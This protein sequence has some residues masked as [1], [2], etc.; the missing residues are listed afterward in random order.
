[1]SN[2]SKMIDV[3]RFKYKNKE[4]PFFDKEEMEKEVEK[5][6]KRQFDFMEMGDLVEEEEDSTKLHNQAFGL[7]EEGKTEEMVKKYKK[8]IEMGNVESMYNLGYHYLFM[9]KDEN[10][11]MKYLKMAADG[12]SVKAMYSIASYHYYTHPIYLDTNYKEMKKYFEMAI[13]KG[14]EK[15]LVFLNHYYTSVFGLGHTKDALVFFYKH[16]KIEL[17]K[18][19]SPFIIIGSF[20]AYH[21]LF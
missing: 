14:D 16:N 20:A 15:S 7:G 13:E 9:E 19:L 1:M 11:G 17:L 18:I 2:C 6:Q 8:A 10:E 3:E 5:M 12:G 21:F 4:L